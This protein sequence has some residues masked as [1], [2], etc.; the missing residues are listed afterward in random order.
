MYISSLLPFREELKNPASRLVSKHIPKSSAD[1]FTGYFMFS[2]S[3]LPPARDFAL[4]ISRPP[5]PI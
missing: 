5:I 2:I 4:K 3:Q 1:E